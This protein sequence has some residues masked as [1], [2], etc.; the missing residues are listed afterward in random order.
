MSNEPSG[1][2]VLNERN[3]QTLAALADLL[4]PASMTMPRASEADKTGA[5][6]ER[7]VK[8][9][10]DWTADFITLLEQS[11][12]K[13]PRHVLAELQTSAPA[14]FGMLAELVAGAYLLNPAI[15]QLIGY[16]G[17]QA[18]PIT[19]MD[20]DMDDLLA[21]VIQRGPIYRPDPT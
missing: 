9:R 13:D 18:I 14:S 20:E 17:Q 3:R 19:G 1:Q 15:R 2:P 21:P 6:I 11:S 16:P 10:P 5:W 8:A 12:G 4:I 7:A